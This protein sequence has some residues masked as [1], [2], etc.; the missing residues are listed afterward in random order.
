MIF[1]D[2][3]EYTISVQPQ[4]ST[5]IC[6]S[7][8]Q[9]KNNKSLKI[10]YL[11]ARSIQ[12]KTE[13]LQF[14]I[15]QTV[16]FDI[17]VITE[18]WLNDTTVNYFL[19]EN[20][21][22]VF[23]CRPNR[24]GGGSAILIKKNIKH[25]T[26]FKFSDDNN[27]FTCV[28]IETSSKEKINISSI[29]RNTIYT[30]LA[31]QT[32]FQQ[33][34]DFLDVTTNTETIIIGDFN[35]DTINKTENVNTYINIMQT[36]NMHIL[37]ENV[38]TR[39]IS[40][41]CLDHIFVNNISR[42]IDIQQLRYDLFD[43][44]LIFIEY[45]NISINT[46][47]SITN[48]K[49]IDHRKLNEMITATPIHLNENDTIDCFYE[50]FINQIN[51]K[52]DNCT[53]TRKT[54]KN[55]TLKPWYNKEL[56]V[57][58][59]AKNFWYKKHL[60]NPMNEYLAEEYRYWRNKT[61]SVRRQNRLNYFNNQFQES[62]GNI[63]KTWQ[64]IKTVLYNGIKPANNIDIPDNTL[65]PNYK[66]KW[67]SDLNKYYINIVKNTN[68]TNSE[69]RFAILYENTNIRHQFEISTTDKNNVIKIIKNMKN[70]SS[71][72]HDNISIKIIKD[73]IE[74][75]AGPITNIINKSIITATVPALMKISK[76][77]PIYKNGN[78]ENHE[79]YRP[80]S[81]LPTVDKI[82]ESVINE[83]LTQY[84]SEYQLLDS[85]QYGFRKLSNTNCALFDLTCSIEKA[86]G[87]NN[88]SAI[89]FIDV[90]K[91]FD[92][93]NR[94]ILLNKLYNMGVKN[95]SHDWFKSYFNT[96]KQ[97]VEVN[98][99][100][101]S[102]EC[103]T[104]G[105][106][107][108][109]V[110]A[111]TLFIIY[112]NELKNLKLNGER[113]LYADDI[114]LVYNEKNIN[115]IT[116]AANEDMKT[117][118]KFMDLHKLTINI[119]KTKIMYIKENSPNRQAVVYN[120]QIVDIATEFNYLGVL[121][122]NNL[123]WKKQVNKLKTKTSQIAGILRRVS[124]VTPKEIYKT[125]YH[126]M[127]HSHILYGAALLNCSSKT[128]VDELQVIQ[129]RAIRNLYNIP[130]RTRISTI[131]ESTNLATIK[132]IINTQQMIQIH[133]II[134]KYLQS[135]QD[136]QFN[137]ENHNYE[138]SSRQN[139]HQ[140]SHSRLTRNRTLYNAVSVYNN[141][142]NESKI[143]NKNAFKKYIKNKNN[144]N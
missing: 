142:P 60:Q 1:N 127:F 73:N 126:S 36:Y 68:D 63:K 82:M 110:L 130:L 25:K 132:E 98:D 31:I 40:N 137:Y 105:I 18:H 114:A 48:N 54:S 34:S 38:I 24:I 27:S 136:L 67:I 88:K 14:I 39:Q 4:I 84:M 93:V 86:L 47:N 143:L 90:K 102:V 12:N 51:M 2:N 96:R 133:G 107:Q 9:F 41:T 78:K 49:H 59:Q 129:N 3:N 21:V 64:N 17:V 66:Q 45:Q 81:I 20:Y 55:N 135:N 61:T 113:F 76:I 6:L 69:N 10:L 35:F 99:A 58:I 70:T 33:L 30:N 83:Q 118:K 72:G 111:A 80:I 44:N 94:S 109:G 50:S 85:Q 123:N 29:Y 116:L 100:K 52:I 19:M 42:C 140:N 95:R 15:T 75:L 120:N 37:Y 122:D 77:I 138:T 56:K 28:Q 87:D 8:I 119:N 23:A 101:S 139:I 104:D 11:N 43:H 121:I 97:Y 32:F 141:L 5:K 92:T 13:E 108:G 103:T 112:L 89:I 7:D 71:K 117:I 144:L 57:S 134:N 106:P 16:D 128:T 22:N 125:I 46:M 74:Q 131:Y 65:I 79:N 53:T 124:K 115:D 26:I 62:A 91:A